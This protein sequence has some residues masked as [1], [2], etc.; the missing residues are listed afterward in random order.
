MQQYF[1]SESVNFTCVGIGINPILQ[2]MLNDTPISEYVFVSTH[3]YPYPL[4]LTL[5]Q[6]LNVS[7]EV[8]N[9][10]IDSD[11]SLNISMTLIVRNVSALNGMSLF[12][13]DHLSLKSNFFNVSIFNGGK[14]IAKGNLSITPFK[15]G[16]LL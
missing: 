3:E 2:W 7:G 16:L 13:E 11:S 15:K 5:P 6:S 12:C 8:T 1:C 9:A 14:I 4:N 10:T